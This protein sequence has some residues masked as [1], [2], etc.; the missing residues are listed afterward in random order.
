ML[1]EVV[2]AD[3][4]ENEDAKTY[5]RLKFPKLKEVNFENLRRFKSF[6][7]SGV[8]SQ[9]LFNQVNFPNMEESNVF[10]LDCI[11]KLLGKEMSITSL[12]KLT[13]M[14]LYDC[15][16]F[17][18]IAESDSIQLLHN[19]EKIYV[20]RCN[21]LK[22]LFDFE[23]IKVTND[24]EIDMLGRLTTLWMF[25]L[26]EVVNITKMVPKGIR[27]FQ[28]LTKLIV[29]NCKSLKYLFSPSTAN[30]LVALQVLHVSDCKSIEEIV[31]K[32]EKQEGTSEIEIVER[33]NLFPMLCDLLLVN[34][35][36][37]QMFCSQNYY[38]SLHSTTSL[39][40]RHCPMMKKFSPLY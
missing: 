6:T 30:S 12:H 3:A 31:G 8:V 17:L 25:S 27:V 28:H 26:P 40:I 18:T 24:A 23:G 16:E 29:L 13:T 5:G 9:T 38:L 1:E 4:Q 37:I 14:S 15:V 36:R 7:S 20:V 11:V 10:H 22:V 39:T 33:M 19:L 21:A 2:S 34:L 32:E 35:P